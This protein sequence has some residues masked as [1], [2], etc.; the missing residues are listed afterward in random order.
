MNPQVWRALLVSGALLLF[1]LTATGCIFGDSVEFFV[2]GFSDGEL[3]VIV[4]AN[5]NTSLC[6]SEGGGIYSCAYF[7]GSEEE[8]IS[9]FEISDVELLLFLFLL[10]PVVVQVPQEAQAFQ[11][12][13]FHQGS[14]ES[15]Q[16]AITAGLDSIPADAEHT[17]TAEPGMQLVIIELPEGAPATGDFSFNFNFR[18]PDT[19]TSLEV[20]P[21]FTARAQTADETYYLPLLPCVTDMASVPALSVPL[22]VGGIVPLPVNTVPACDNVTYQIGPDAPADDMLFLPLVQQ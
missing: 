9:R 19:L 17:L 2:S 14:G 13:Y 6:D 20:K 21:L 11:G 16:L 12:S 18:V 22:P 4:S 8:R 3:T 7:P 15:G 10:D 5:A 1:A